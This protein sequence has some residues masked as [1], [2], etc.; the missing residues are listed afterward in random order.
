MT[1][2]KQAVEHSCFTLWSQWIE[3]VPRDHNNNSRN[4]K[5]V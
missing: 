4:K 2:K 3:I 1:T 5:P